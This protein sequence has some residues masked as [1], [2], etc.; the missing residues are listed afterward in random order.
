MKNFKWEPRYTTISVYTFLVIAASMLFG[1][2]VLRLDNVW[3]FLQSIVKYLIPFVYGFGLAFILSPLLRMSEKLI[4]SGITS[5]KLRRNIAL[6]ITYLFAL[7]LL[8]IFFVVVI[9]T[10]AESVTALAKNIAYYSTQVDTMVSQ[11]IAII[12]IDNIPKEVVS[13]IDQ[14][15]NSVTQFVV[16][17]LLHAVTLTSRVTAGAIDVVMG[18][19]ISIYMLANKER[20]IAQCKKILHAALPERSVQALINVAHD[21]NIKF[22]GFLI[23]K[24]IDSIIIGLMCAAGMWIFKM[25]FITLVSLIIG[26]TNI[27]PYFGPFIGAIPGF[28][29]VFIGG[30]FWQ[31][32]GF[33]VF[34]LVLQQFDGNVL[35]PAILGQS[36]GLDAMWVIFAILLFGGLYGFVGMVIGVPLL[37]V[38]FGIIGDLINTRLRHK[39]MSEE[40]ESYASEKHPLLATRKKK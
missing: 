27:V 37:S 26:V 11:I 25:P 35:G 32:V 8:V 22:S 34:V 40:T 36:T 15:V 28:I 24:I 31:A 23:G 14:M 1:A 2:F 17:T 7:L 30:G 10:L 18:V 21:S 16:N 12:P 6:L 9:P 38:L 5:G 39:G 33:A 19:I 29:L 13:S 4:G 20:L 3:D